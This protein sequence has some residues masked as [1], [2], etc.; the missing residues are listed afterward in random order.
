MFFES[1][2]KVSPLDVMIPP[3][4]TSVVP[5]KDAAL[6]I[7]LATERV[8]S[9]FGKDLVAA[10]FRMVAPNQLPLRINWF[11]AIDIG[12]YDI[13]GDRTALRAVQPAVRAPHQTVGDRMRVLQAESLQVDDRVVVGNVVVVSIWIK[14]Q[15]GRIQHP[16]AASTTCDGGTHVQAFEKRFVAIERSVSIGIFVDRDFVSSAERR[17]C[18]VGRRRRHRVVNVAPKVVAA[19]NF[20]TGGMRVLCILNDPH[21]PPLVE[22]QENRLP[23][24]WFGQHLVDGQIVGDPQTGKRLGRTQPARAGFLNRSRR[25]R[26]KPLLGRQVGSVN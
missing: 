16:R 8:A 23:H 20:Q 9:T 4:F 26:V 19:D 24:G 1:L 2:A 11:V 13:A 18:R 21:P 17:V 15:V 6:G 25:R 22:V 10:G 5:R 12:T 14:K 7:D 3:C